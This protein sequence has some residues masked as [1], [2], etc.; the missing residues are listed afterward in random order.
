V[1]TGNEQDRLMLR[2]SDGQVPYYD[3][4]V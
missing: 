3:G 4:E 2:R 1:W